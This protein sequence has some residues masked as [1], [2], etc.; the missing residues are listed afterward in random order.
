MSEFQ[1]PMRDAP[2]TALSNYAHKRVA[3]TRSCSAGQHVGII[4]WPL[5][6]RQVRNI[7]I[8]DHCCSIAGTTPS[9]QAQGSSAD[10]C[11]HLPASL[12][13][14]YCLEVRSFRLQ[15]GAHRKYDHG[16]NEDKWHQPR[17]V[18]HSS[19][20]TKLMDLRTLYDLVFLHNES[21]QCPVNWH[22]P[23]LICNINV[24]MIHGHF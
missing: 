3:Y 14:L 19:L 22:T 8:C 12:H 2:V 7:Y 20:D 9:D 17:K 24:L 21:A 4:Q 15:D 23:N 6:K 1:Q 13:V 18:I 16:I 11:Y 5:V 10:P